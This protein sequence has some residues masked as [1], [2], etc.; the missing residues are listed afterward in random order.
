MT[1]CSIASNAVE[2]PPA[3]ENGTG[4]RI[5]E[6]VDGRCRELSLDAIDR[7]AR[8]ERLRARG[9]DCGREFAGGA[10]EVVRGTGHSRITGKRSVPSVERSRACG[11]R[12]S[13]Q[14][15]KAVPEGPLSNQAFALGT[16][17]KV[18]D[19]SPPTKLRGAFSDA[20]DAPSP[21]HLA[22]APELLPAPHSR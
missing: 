6:K 8:V 11:A 15:S 21:S 17:V 18:L 9:D 19:D 13:R 20:A 4:L 1:P 2:S 14:G 16:S 3:G 10:H 7:S 22:V 12:P 5:R